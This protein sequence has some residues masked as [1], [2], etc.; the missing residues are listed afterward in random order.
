MKHVSPLQLTQLAST[1]AS[2][3]RGQKSQPIFTGHCNNRRELF[4][5]ERSTF[6]PLVAPNVDFPN[7][8][9]GI[10]TG[11]LIPYQPTEQRRSCCQVIVERFRREPLAFAPHLK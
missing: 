5:C 11:D 4:R 2:V 6:E 8:R 9:Q 10:A 1:Q 7:T 3:V